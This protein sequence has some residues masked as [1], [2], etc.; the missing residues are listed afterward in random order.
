[1]NEKKK[2]YHV[3]ALGCRTNQY[4]AQAFQDQ[5]GALGWEAAKKGEEADLC[6][7]NTCTVTESADGSSRNE[8]RR[9]LKKNPAAKVLVT[10]CYAERDPKTIASLGEDVHVVPNAEKEVALRQIFP[11]LETLPEFSIKRFEAH[12]RAFLKVQDGCNSY[13]TYCIIPYVRGRSRSRD[14]KE[15][16]EEAKRLLSEGYKEIVLTGINIGDFDGGATLADLVR[17]VDALPG[18]KRLRISSID[19]DE[20]DEDLADAVLNGKNTCSSMHIVLQSGSNVVLKRMNRKY[21]RQMFMETIEKLR[22][23]NPEFTFTTDVIVGFPGETEVDHQETLDVIRKVRFAKVHMFPYSSRPRT[24]SALYPN[25]VSDEI[26]RNRKQE[27]LREDEKASY[28]LRKEYVGKKMSIL[29]E[30]GEGAISGHTE[31]FLPVILPGEKME[32]NQ[33]IDVELIEN[34]PKGLIGRVISNA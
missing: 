29:T 20:V 15:V 23:A 24:R 21:T 32:P 9:A 26:K 12:T 7:V 13:C 25:Q 6:I 11:D 1:M 30:G 8:V 31:N 19:P 2:R 14:I 17:A 18:L 16:V 33:L 22:L 27:V 34:T 5:L 28:E 10:G 3:T 4:E